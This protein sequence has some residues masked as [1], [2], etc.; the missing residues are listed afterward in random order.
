M[1]SFIWLIIQYLPTHS[2]R[3]HIHSFVCSLRCF[4]GYGNTGTEKHSQRMSNKWI[5]W[6]FCEVIQGH[7]KWNCW[8]GYRGL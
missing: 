3:R 6:I 5:W 7:S 2:R 4:A 8:K 1:F